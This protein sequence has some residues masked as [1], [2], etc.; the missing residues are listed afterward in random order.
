MPSHESRVTSHDSI[1]IVPPGADAPRLVKRPEKTVFQYLGRID[2]PRQIASASANSRMVYDFRTG[3]VQT[4][5]AWIRPD[6]L[7]GSEAGDFVRL[8]TTWERMVQARAGAAGTSV[9]PS[10]SSDR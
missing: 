4:G 7:A 9:R 8:I 1:T 10:P 6:T 5:G 3:R 2:R